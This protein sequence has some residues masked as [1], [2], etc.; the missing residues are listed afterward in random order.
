MTTATGGAFGDLMVFVCNIMGH[1]H[2]QC[3]SRYITIV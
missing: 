1:E 3:M 2:H